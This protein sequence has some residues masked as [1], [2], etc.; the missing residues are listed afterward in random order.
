MTSAAAPL[1]LALL[2]TSS[3][4]EHHL[5]AFRRAGGASVDIVFSQEPSRAAT[6]AQSN[7]IAEHSAELDA[8]LSDARIDAAIIV[9]EPS[10]HASLAMAALKAGKPVLVEK[11]LDADPDQAASLAAFAKS[12]NIPA[13]IVAQRRF[14]PAVVAIKRDL[15]GLNVPGAAKLEMRWSRNADYYLAGDGW[16]ATQAGAVFLNQGIHWLD[17]LIWLFGDPASVQVEARAT[18]DFLSCA[19]EVEAQIKFSSGV[20]VSCF[21]TTNAPIQQ[22]DLLRIDCDRRILNYDDYSRKFNHARGFWQRLLGRKPTQLDLLRLQAE[23]FIG[24]VRGLHPPRAGLDDGLAALRLAM[25]L[26]PPLKEN[27]KASYS[28]SL[29]P[30]L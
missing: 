6:F 27:R 10:R 18:R 3:I 14:E 25:A 20:E 13:A 8:I 30:Q 11:P 4:A 15:A 7:G 9:T 23:D 16:R 1:R 17:L 12:Q 28:G 24:A 2:G 29:N 26:S 5:A 22:P 19:D 21:A